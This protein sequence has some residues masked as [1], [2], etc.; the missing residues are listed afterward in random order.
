MQEVYLIISQYQ[1]R[2]KVHG[3]CTK[4]KACEQFKIID[5]CKPDYLIRE[6]KFPFNVKFYELDEDGTKNLI[7]H[8]YIEKRP[9]YE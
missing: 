3:V 7:E 9:F 1:G 8:L 4:E 6:Q 5:S 2:S